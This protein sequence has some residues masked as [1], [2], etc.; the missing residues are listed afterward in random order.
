MAL[1]PDG[2]GGI[3]SA[4]G[5]EG[6]IQDLIKHGV[7]VV[8]M[9]AVDNCLVR[10]ADPAFIGMFI[11]RG[12]DV[13]SKSVPKIDPK[14]SV[15]VLCRR[16][17]DQRL[18]VAE[19]SE[20]DPTLTDAADAEGNLLFNEANIANHLFTTTFLQKICLNPDF[21]LHFH[22]A[23]KK[24]P[25]IDLETGQAKNPPPYGIKLE[26]FI[27]DALE[28]SKS[29]VVFQVSRS[30]EFAPLKNASRSSPEDTPEACS[31]RLSELHKS[32]LAAA[33]AILQGDGLCEISPLLSY[34][35]EGLDRY[36]GVT[37]QLP[38]HL[39]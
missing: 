28:F 20:L 14:E 25:S 24:I 31:N 29:P 27:F 36:V 16:E 18:V 3:Y 37:I 19:Y 12:A 26:A 5:R 7:E 38:K 34:G 10:M 1:A 11:K 30:S 21:R 23:K 33:G 4:M 35:G 6:V 39:E 8:H 15:G 13:A 32:W 17:S 9:H 2:N 22:V